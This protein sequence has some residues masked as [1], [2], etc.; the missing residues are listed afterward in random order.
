MR[1]IRVVFLLGLMAA[2]PLAAE[3][4]TSLPLPPADIL[5]PDDKASPEPQPSTSPAAPA[6]GFTPSERIKA[7]QSVAFPVDI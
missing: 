5:K 2:A 3:D 7:D 1:T 4:Q 6:P